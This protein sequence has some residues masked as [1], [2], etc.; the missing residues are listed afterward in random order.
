MAEEKPHR[1]EGQ[2]SGQD[3]RPSEHNEDDGS[4]HDVT[5]G[6]P[7]FHDRATEH[8]HKSLRSAAPLW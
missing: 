5:A 1:Q 2:C 6:T 7:S 8:M 3:E 4:A